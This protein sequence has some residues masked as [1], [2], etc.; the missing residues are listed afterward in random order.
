MKRNLISAQNLINTRGFYSDFAYSTL[1]FKTDVNLDLLDG[2][3]HMSS[4][5]KI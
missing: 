2:I 3:S 5:T 1:L 4:Q